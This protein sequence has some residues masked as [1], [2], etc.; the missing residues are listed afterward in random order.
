M[1]H[2]VKLA[3]DL[4]CLGRGQVSP[5][6]LSG[7]L[8]LRGIGYIHAEDYAISEI[9]LV[10]I[11]LIDDGVPEIVLAPSSRLFEKRWPA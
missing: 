3:H 6:A 2:H 11:A 7:A 10:R 1:A 4:L 8:R 9:K 5:L